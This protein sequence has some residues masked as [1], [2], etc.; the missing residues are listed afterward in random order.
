MKPG[1]F[2]RMILILVLRRFHLGWR[3]LRSGEAGPGLGVPAAESA[4]SRF[5]GA[6]PSVG[7]IMLAVVVV[8]VVVG[9][10]PRLRHGC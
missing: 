9:V 8:V 6:V 2:G 7:V 10:L 1:T 3:R 5:R 4:E